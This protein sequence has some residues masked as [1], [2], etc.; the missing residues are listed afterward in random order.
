V[1]NQLK[2]TEF[3]N[4]SHLLD[5][6]RLAVEKVRDDMTQNAGVTTHK[7]Q[8]CDLRCKWANAAKLEALDGSCHTFQSLWC[9][10]LDKHVTK[11]SPCAVLFGRRRPTAKF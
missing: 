4:F 9:Q 8:W 7:I 11:N 2:W 5:Y 6:T 10:K 3:I 1:S